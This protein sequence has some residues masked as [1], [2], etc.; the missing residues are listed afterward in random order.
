MLTRILGSRTCMI[1]LQLVDLPV[2]HPVGEEIVMHA[3]SLSKVQ[4]FVQF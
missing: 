1:H 3:A 2:N 4:L